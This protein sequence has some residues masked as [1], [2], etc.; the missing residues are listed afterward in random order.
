[1]PR[2]GSGGGGISCALCVFG[3]ELSSLEAVETFL[4]WGFG[5]ILAINRWSMI[6]NVNALTLHPHQRHHD[7]SGSDAGTFIV[8]APL[9]LLSYAP[10]LIS[11][12][13][14]DKTNPLWFP[15]AKRIELRVWVPTLALFSFVLLAQVAPSALLERLHMAAGHIL[16]RIHDPLAITRLLEYSKMPQRA[17]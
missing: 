1:M 3:R 10:L 7:R 11:E 6:I 4:G 9:M 13:L 5:G 8:A 12:F 2:G 16:R 17:R 14:A 15:Q